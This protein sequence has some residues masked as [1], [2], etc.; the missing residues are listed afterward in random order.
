MAQNLM[1]ERLWKID[2]RKKSIYLEQGIFYSAGPKVQ[3]RLVGLRHSDKGGHERIVFDFNTPEPPRVYGHLAQG[4]QKL[5][6]DFFNSTMES[7]L[8]FPGQSRY[9]KNVNFFPLGPESLSVEIKF[10]MATSADIFHLS[11]PGRIV[12]DVK[13]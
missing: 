12:I 13:K 2:S 5:Y 9:V 4:E 11:S 10:K 3:S 1:K 7:P 6:V 8:A